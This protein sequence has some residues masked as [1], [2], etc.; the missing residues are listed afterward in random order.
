MHAKPTKNKIMGAII[1]LMS[2]MLL[3][4]LYTPKPV[5]AITSLPELIGSPI[6]VFNKLPKA[7]QDTII[8]FLGL[9]ALT[10][11]ICIFIGVSKNI[12]KTS[13]GS[14]TK[15]AK[16]S[17]GGVLDNISILIVIIVG[18]LVIGVGGALILGLSTTSAAP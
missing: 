5:A 17:T 14:S 9:L 15:D 13:V 10:L 2:T 16:L 8:W 1:R 12:I 3:L 6:S 11:I 7:S 4:I 18:S